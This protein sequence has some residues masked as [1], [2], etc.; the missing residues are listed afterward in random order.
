MRLVDIF[1]DGDGLGQRPAFD[2]E[3][4]NRAEGADP[5]VVV[6]VLFARV[7]I[8]RDLPISDTL[9]IQRDTDAKR[10]LRT[11]EPIHV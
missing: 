4:W 1:K 9:E 6:A 8:D 10:R 2:H 5:S 11:P 7:E 3:R